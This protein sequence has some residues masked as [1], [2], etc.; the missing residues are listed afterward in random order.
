MV[1]IILEIINKIIT[2]DNIKYILIIGCIL[3]VGYF[4][5]FSNKTKNF[6]IKSLG[7][8][9]FL[10]YSETIDTLSINIDTTLIINEWVSANVELFKPIIKQDTSIIIRKD[11]TIINNDTTIILSPVIEIN[12]LSEF[13]SII[14]DSLLEGKITTII[15]FN[16]Q[17]LL[18]QD[19]DYKPKFPKFITKT[20]TIEKVIEKEYKNQYNIGIGGKANTIGDL[21]I[22]GAYQN[23]K[24]WQ[25]QGSYNFSDNT[26]NYIEVGIIKFF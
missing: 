11:T 21:G 7:G 23:N 1:K 17:K 26:N 14:S 3:L 18:S 9:T 16:K 8:Y 19:F 10:E 6:I 20:I 15:D 24:G 4:I 13:S 22:I 2:K 12:K 5:I 25:F